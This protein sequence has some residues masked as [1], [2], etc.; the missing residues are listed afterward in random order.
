MCGINVATGWYYDKV[1]R[2]N[3]ATKHRGVSQAV[4]SNGEQ[5]IGIGHVRLPI[6]GL[7]RVGDQ[8]IFIGDHVFAFV[9]EFLNYKEKEPM[10][11]TDGPTAARAYLEEGP[12]GLS[13]FDGFWSMVHFDKERGVLRVIQ[14]PIGK[15]PTYFHVSGEGLIISSELKGLMAVHEF[16]DDELNLSATLKFG[17]C[18][19]NTT[20]LKSVR[21][22]PGG[23]VLEYS[24]RDNSICIWPYVLIEPEAGNLRELMTTAVRNRLVSDVPVS[25]LL[26]GGLD[27]TIVYQLT[28]ELTTDFTVFHVDNEEAEYLNYLDF[29]SSVKV[30]PVSLDNPTDLGTILRANEGPSDMGSVIPQYELAKA[31]RRHGLD[32][33]ISGDGADELFGGYKRASEYD[34]QYSDIFH[35]LPSYHL[36]RLDKLMMAHTIELRCPFLSIPVI[37]HAMTIP[38]RHRTCKQVLKEVFADIVPKAIRDRVKEP[39]R[40]SEARKS[41]ADWRNTLNDE[42][43]KIRERM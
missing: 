41:K 43:R 36:P 8:P 10:A 12:I 14:D 31:I 30:I 11:K 38:H 3:E 7:G 27:S 17:Y 42:W 9:G 22:I 32:V 21:R 6:Q 28:K 20:P 23:C 13:R 15:K 37:Q 16:E 4:Y 1:D 40:H 35:E 33:A 29:P 26:S 18:P 39:L 5:A 19:D 25:L 34:S 2:M 24:I